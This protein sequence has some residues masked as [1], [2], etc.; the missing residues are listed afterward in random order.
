MLTYSLYAYKYLDGKVTDKTFKF[1]ITEVDDTGAEV[2]DGYKT[3]STNS[4]DEGKIE[5]NGIKYSQ[6]G[7]YYYKVKEVIEDTAYEYDKSEY[8]VKVVVNDN[9]EKFTISSV[10]LLDAADMVFNNKTVKASSD[11]DEKEEEN[12]NP[13]TGSFIRT[14]VIILFAISMFTVVFMYKKFSYLK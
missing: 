4:D 2:P 11:T 6:A 3:T 9:G 13:N 10:E 12:P 1:S 14:V 5:F 7:T 8:T